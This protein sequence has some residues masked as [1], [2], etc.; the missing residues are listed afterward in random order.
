[1]ADKKKFSVL[2]GKGVPI[3]FLVI[4]F[5]FF[6]LQK[7]LAQQFPDTIWIPV[8]FYDFHS[9]ESNPEFEVDHNGSLRMGMVADTLNA[10]K[11]PVLGSKPFFNYYIHK[12]F[13]PWQAG[14]VTIPEYADRNG[15][16]HEIVTV[17][18]DTAFKNIVIK[19]SLPFT[20]IGDGVY[21]FERS[22]ENRT[23]EFFWLD[24][25][26]FGIEERSHNYSFTM[27][28]HT[29][30]TYNRGL[31]FEFLGDDDVWAFI[32]G[33]LAMDIGGIH[34]SLEDEIDLDAIADTFGLQAGRKYDFDFF[35]AER[36]TSN[37][38]IKITTNLFTPL[39]NLRLYSKPG[40]PDQNEEFII[41]SGDTIAAGEQFSIYGHAFDTLG[42]R[43]D[44]DNLINLELVDP[45]NRAELVSSG[46]GSITIFPKTP[47]TTISITATFIN[48]EDPYAKPIKSTVQLVIGPG[49]AVA[50]SAV[51]GDSDGDGYI[52]QVDVYFN[53]KV[54][55]NQKMKDAF[56]VIF[57]GTPFQ[58]DSI[59]SINDGSVVRLFLEEKITDQLQTDWKPLVNIMD[60][61]GLAPVSG[62][63]S[64]DGAGPVVNKA[65]F[66]SGSLSNEQSIG[67]P[68]SI[69]VTISELINWP[70]SA[71]SDPN[72]IFR[73]YHNNNVVQN[74][75][76]SMIVVDDSTAIL[77]VSEKITVDAGRDSIQLNSSGG[78][79]DKPGNRP[80]IN[81]RKAAIEWGVITLQ[82]IPSNNPFSPGVTEIDPRI[83]ER[84]APVI[85][86]QTKISGGTGTMGTVIRL[87][88]KG[89]P[90]KVMKVDS[91]IDSAYG[92]VVV[93][94]VVGNLVRS[95]LYVFKVEGNDYGI[96]WDGYNKKRRS[97]GRGTYLFSVVTTDVDNKTDK[98]QFKIGVTRKQIK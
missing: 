30:F 80:H 60:I 61:K 88:V 67:T 71:N 31:I 83:R 85:K 49:D 53:S 65:K 44:W 69:R 22:G 82:Y 16:K 8:T 74:P 54:A 15:V 94:D 43:E 86:R 51:T 3:N 81:S 75:F 47:F 10:N 64:K 50:D 38:R 18:Y 68:D 40:N 57:R 97:V 26:G 23:D 25:K 89:K 66:Y 87:E 34:V 6:F 41:I 17:T 36:H 55:F 14:D 72:Q 73:L 90:L 79:T 46:N 48:P 96:Y 37:S 93:Y 92:R 91:K 11:K 63:E 2:V 78:V 76:T 70:V 24:E 33:K 7:S 20:H 59:S 27:E 21:Q 5:T 45:Q 62:M 29:T 4:I 13:E 28:M 98:K 58:I 39:A 42:W 56:E 9:D 77:I 35:Y 32:N 95:D 19:D 84:F 1:M 52:D 12:W